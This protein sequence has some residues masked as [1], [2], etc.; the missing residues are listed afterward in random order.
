MHGT[1]DEVVS[2]EDVKARFED[3]RGTKELIVFDEYDHVDLDH[4]EGLARQLG[5]ASRWF[6]RHLCYKL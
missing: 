3:I 6:A 2:I 5:E 1:L 4:G